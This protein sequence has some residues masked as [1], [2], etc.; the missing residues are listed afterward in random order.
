[1]AISGVFTGTGVSGV[2]SAAGGAFD[3]ALGAF[4]GAI[5]LE[6]SIDLGAT[7]QPVGAD[8]YGTAATYAGSTSLTVDEPQAGAQFRLNCTSLLSG[9]PTWQIGRA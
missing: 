6:R 5:T 3:F 2:Y 8:A 9:T 7:W 4:T 1:M